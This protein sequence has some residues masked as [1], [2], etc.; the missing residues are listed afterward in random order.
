M[1][2]LNNKNFQ[3]SDGAVQGSRGSCFYRV[4]VIQYVYVKA[5]ECTSAAFCWK[6]F[7]DNTF[8]IWPHRIDK[9]DIFSDCIIKVDP[10]KKILF[11]MEVATDTL[12]PFNI[13]FKLDK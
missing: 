4:M 5:L 12:Q 8:I 10:T 1:S 9:L 3:Q 6:R 11:I 7:R 13:K 2:F